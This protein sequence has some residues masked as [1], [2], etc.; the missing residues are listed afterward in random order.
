V[1]YADFGDP[2]SLNQYTYVRNI[3]TVMVDVDGHWPALLEPDTMEKIGQVTAQVAKEGGKMLLRGAAATVGRV[4]VGTT[5][6][7]AA[8]AASPYI[9]T[10]GQSK[11]DE[12]AQIQQA[13]RERAEQNG[14][15]DPQQRPA[16]VI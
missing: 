7:I 16:A 11:A 5:V 13:S 10:V 6:I 2:Q 15:V 14:G 1:P 3:P 4:A 12:Q 9:Q 8:Y